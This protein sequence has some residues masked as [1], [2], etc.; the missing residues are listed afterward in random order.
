MTDRIIALW[1]A[2]ERD[3]KGFAPAELE[4][5]ARAFRRRIALRDAIEYAAS[6]LVAAIF[7]YYA[8]AARDWR[9]TAACALVIVGMAVVVRGLWSRRLTPL[10]AALGEASLRY[11]RDQL[12]RQRD[13]LVSVW[14]WYI[15]PTIPG[16]IAFAAVVASIAA[17]RTASD[18][19]WLVMLP[20]LA[21]VFTVFYAI[22]RLNLRAARALQAEI[23]QLDRGCDEP[24]SPSAAVDTHR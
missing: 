9:M 19:A 24:D 11:H 2:E 22:H 14:R 23:D 5:K 13:A 20:T 21:F 16:V 4:R 10:P 6:A 3:A 1:Q 18:L 12:V 8:W 15:A 17:E 7:V